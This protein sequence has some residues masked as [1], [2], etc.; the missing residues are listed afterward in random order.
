MGTY[1]RGGHWRRSRNGGM[2][3]VSGHSVTREAPG[4][5]PS[6][7]WSSSTWSSSST[8]WLPSSSPSPPSQP[9]PVRNAALPYSSRWV[10]PNA[11]CP[12]C[13]AAVYFWSN[14]LGS[15]VYFDEMGP[16]W[17]KHPCTD[18]RVGGVGSGSGAGYFWKTG[19]EPTASALD[20]RL[21][22]AA[23]PPEAFEVERVTVH[24]QDS[25][26]HVRRRGWVRRRT[27]FVVPMLLSW[28]PGHVFVTD[29]KLSFVHAATLEVLEFPAVTAR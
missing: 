5:R 27:V 24:G 20:F 11:R 29:R 7:R 12:V 6:T 4:S 28:M 26:L 2:H 17:P 14:S 16:P 13:G 22:F 23:P 19:P 1:Q 9:Q 3:W 21:R 15:R 8:S 18:A 25:W 10:K